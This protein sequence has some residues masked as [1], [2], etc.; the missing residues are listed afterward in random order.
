MKDETPLS[1]RNAVASD[2]KSLPPMARRI[3]EETF[4]HLFEPAAFAAFCDSAYGEDGSMVQDLGDPRILWRIAEAAGEPVG[5]AKLRPWGA[6]APDAAPGALELQQIYVT[7]QWH[8]K[9]VAS[10][11][12]DWGVSAARQ[13]DAT[14]LYLTVFDHNERAKAFYSKCGFSEVGRCTFTLGGREYDDR[15][16][17]KPL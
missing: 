4:A 7:A 1:Y 3:F 6:P 14:E 11:L 2:T 9:G 13:L 16:W 12:M 10:E 5:Y 17:L 15:V 8:G